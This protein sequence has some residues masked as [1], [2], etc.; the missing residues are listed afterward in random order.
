[1]E[2]RLALKQALG[3]PLLT[4]PTLFIKGALLGG[5]D[6]LRETLASGR[7][8]DLLQAPRQA[9][10]GALAAFHDPVKL[11]V[12]PRGQHWYCFQLH[13]YANLVRAISAVHV[14]LFSIFLALQATWPVVAAILLW[15]VAVDL[16]VFV[17]TG[18][19]PFAP[20]GTL[21][22]M[23]VWRFRGN[24]VNSLAYK[25][26]FGYYIFSILLLLLC[27]PSLHSEECVTGGAARNLVVGL[28]I[29]SVLLAIL[30]F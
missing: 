7:F 26:V 17:L 11:L 20:V 19:T 14:L 4:F 29:N 12:G 18:P 10:P 8:D 3:V 28:L 13:V 6:Q 1:M 5:L 21:T 23:L 9:F 2:T 30:R 25:F 22:T 16:F 27:R 24:A 15:V